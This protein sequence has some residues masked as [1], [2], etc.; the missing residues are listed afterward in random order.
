MEKFCKI[1]EILYGK[2]KYQVLVQR[3]KF[4]AFNRETNSDDL[5]YTISISTCIRGDIWDYMIDCNTEEEL[6]Q[7]FEDFAASN[8]REALISLLDMAD[9]KDDAG[10]ATDERTHDE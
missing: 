2:T 5:I 10:R 1:F 9:D 8:A 7:G 3:D 4:F 6:D